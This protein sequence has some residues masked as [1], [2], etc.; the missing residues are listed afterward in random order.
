MWLDNK[1]V[2]F[3]Y[4]LDGEEVIDLIMKQ[5]TYGGKPKVTITIVDSGVLPVQ[6]SDLKIVPVATK[7]SL[8]L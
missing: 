5:G 3:G 8:Q 2:V 6:G 7:S 4:V 1:N